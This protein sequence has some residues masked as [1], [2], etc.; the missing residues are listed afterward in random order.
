MRLFNL[1]H[2]SSGFTLVEITVAALI[3]S[4]AITGLFAT[5]T[6]L[7][8]PSAEAFEEV[9]AAYI[10]KGVLEELRSAIDAQ[11]WENPDPES[12]A[13]V[14]GETYTLDPVEYEGLNYSISY[15]VTGNS[16][17]GRFVDITISW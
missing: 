9:Q 2:N 16:I 14:E 7:N 10:A 3:F 5:I 13:L 17:G 6:S 15:E 11:I 1:Q 12:Y 8:R 4:L